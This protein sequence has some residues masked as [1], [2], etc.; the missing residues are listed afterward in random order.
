MSS[1][2]GSS[3]SRDQACISYLLCIGKWVLDLCVGKSIPW[4]ISQMGVQTETNG[5]QSSN[6]SQHTNPLTQLC[7]S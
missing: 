5:E 3:Q 2:R 7:Y 6:S 1:P 4:Y